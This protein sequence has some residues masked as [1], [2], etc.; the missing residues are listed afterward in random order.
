M[1]EIYFLAEI[2]VNHEGS[3]DLAIEMIRTASIAGANGVKFQ[4]YKAETL[5]AINSPSYWDTKKENEKSQYSLF[6]KH[7]K[8]ELEFYLPLIQECKKNKIDFV[9]TCF[10]QELVNIFDRYVPFHKISSSDITNLPLIE[11]IITKK[12]PI[13][14][15]TGASSLEEIRSSVEFIRSKT[16]IK[17]TI[18]HC[19]L[20][21][22]CAF[23]NANIRMID[24]LQSFLKEY[25]VEVGYSCHV[26]IPEGTDCLISAI[27]RGAIFIEKHFTNSRLKKGNDHYHAMTAED[28]KL[29]RDKEKF[30]NIIKGTG[31][32]NLEI[33]NIARKNARRGVYAAKSIDV[34]ETITFKHL[35]ILRPTNEIEPC[36]INQIIGKKAIKKII[37]GESLEKIF[38]K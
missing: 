27:E 2:G 36:E 9:V 32:P 30:L 29:F 28:L 24:T 38:F 6:Q 4:C 3:Q 37:K 21:Y 20:N 15:S 13:V 31:K 33:Q 35:S 10:D 23:E 5:A 14:L 25:N 7:E 12:K 22:P 16:Q 1:S 8:F 18:L 26:P 17:L 34:D 19:V 11:H